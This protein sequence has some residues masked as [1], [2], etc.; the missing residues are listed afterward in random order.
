M[1]KGKY[2]LKYSSNSRDTKTA[3]QDYEEEEFPL[4]HSG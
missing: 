2:S 3:I 4:W 1:K